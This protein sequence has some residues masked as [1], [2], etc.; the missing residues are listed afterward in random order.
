MNIIKRSG[1]EAVFDRS[2]IR[3]A[4]IKA[5]ESVYKDHRLSTA[6]IN[7]IVDIVTD[8]CEGMNRAAN[9]EEVQDMVEEEL[10]RAGAY[11]IANHYITYRY[12]RALVRQANTTDEQILSLIECSNEEVK[13]ENSNKNPTVNSVQRDYMAGEVSKD[14]TKRFLLPKDIVKA[15]EEGIIHFHDSDYFAQH[16][17]NC[18]LVNLEDML[19]NGTVIS[20]TMIDKP[21]SFST[22]CNIA[23][24]AVAQIASSQ[25]GG[26]SIS[27]SHL[28]PFVQISREKF[29][30]DV[31]EEFASEGLEMSDD[32]INDIAE[33]RVRRE[34][35]QGVQMIQ[36]QVITL[37]TTN[38]QAPFITVFM[39]LNEV[40]DGQTKDDLALII[41]EMLRQRIQGV[42]NEK[43][44]YITP[45]FP[46]LI[47]VLEEDNIKEGTRF[48][49]L[50]KLAAQCTAKRMVPDYIS[51]KVMLENKVDANGEGHC[52]TC[53]GCRSFLT[54][55]LDENGNPK[56]YG[57]FNQGVVTLNLV[58]IACSSGGDMDKFWEIMDERLALCYRALMCRHKRLLGT[59]SDVAPILWQNGALARL[60]KGETIDKLLFGGYSTIS[61]GYAGLCEC[62]R[63][64]TGKSHT[65]PEATPFALEVMR[66]LNK[67]CKRWKLENNIDFSLYGTPLE[68]TTYKFAKCLQKRFG[69]IEGVTDRNY[70]TNSYHVH[71]TEEI[72]AFAKLEFESQFQKLSPGGAISYVEV[73]DMKN[74]LDAVLSVMQFIYDHIMYAELNTKSDY[75][76]CCGYDG[77]IEV[78]EDDQGKLI[79]K[80]PN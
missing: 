9:V 80:C 24:Q 48:W 23:T 37:M 61:L 34:I 72:D 17:H 2:K 52:Y 50:T 30:E 64:M 21:H 18:C 66:Y 13:Q 11:Q 49:E 54:P 45:A 12:R 5:N 35:K 19:Q 77:E 41:E 42:K 76:Q 26:Q 63:Y 1:K 65:D 6:E 69:I 25:Y 75:C 79:W 47:Y 70:I 15:H 27:L 28:A 51:E 57:R 59:K 60:K 62:T 10:M 40:P 3:A 33:K 74:N 8:K 56:Y 78:V 73:P 32:I 39:Y 31:R 16:M 36:Y 71:V 38:G 46:K 53:M 44:V 43:G 7:R 22:A 67:A 20:E 29:R 68:S 58:D 4:V 55:Y 14:I